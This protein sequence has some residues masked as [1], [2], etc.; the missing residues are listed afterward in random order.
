MRKGRFGIVL[1]LYPILAFACV[2]IGQPILCALV[3]GVALFAERDEWASRQTLQALVLC[4]VTELAQSVLLYVVD[5]FPK[6]ITAFR[7]LG[8][9][10]N[11]LSGVIYLGAIVFSILAILRVMKDREA[12][13]PLVADLAFRAFGKRKPRPVPPMPGQFVPPYPQQGPGQPVPPPYHQPYQQG[14]PNQPPF[15]QAP[16]A[17]Q[18]P[19][20]APPQPG[21]RPD[22]SNNS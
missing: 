13:L 4:A 22:D 8:I 2:I 5:L 9:L 21:K 3:F 12:D 16:P 14:A 1:C 6:Y 20:Q 17:Q 19:F 18:P 10:L 7:L 11:I 15:H